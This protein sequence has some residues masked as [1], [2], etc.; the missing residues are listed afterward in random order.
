MITGE[1]IRLRAM[2]RTDV[3]LFVPWLNDPEVRNGI[4][5]YLPVS[6]VG[7]EAWFENMIKGP[8]DEQPMMIEVRQAESW[9]PIGNM[10][11]F[12]INRRVRSAE[13]GILIG[14]KNYWNR[15]YGTEAMRMI[16]QHGFDTLNLNRLFLRV[17]RTNPRA[18]R[19]YEKAGFVH[20]GVQRAAEFRDGEYVDIL[21]MSVLRGEWQARQ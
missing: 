8:A 6:L 7:E 21:M 19:A 4:S 12:G 15:G 20:E 13:I 10:G 14:D 1:R 16:L 11:I 18:I 2:E 9:T 3:P 17:Y 5:L